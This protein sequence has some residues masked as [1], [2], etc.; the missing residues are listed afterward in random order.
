MFDTNIYNHILDGSIG[1]ENIRGKALFFATHIQIDELRNTSN[2]ARKEAL[3]TVFEQVAESE[4]PT[5][6]F[7][8]GVSRLHKAKLGGESVIPTETPIW[9]ISTFDGCKWNDDTNLYE[10]IKKTLDALN[11]N[12]KNNIQDALIAETA[13][14]NSITLITHDIDLFK[15]ATFFNCSCANLYQV[16]KEIK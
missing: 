10:L 7:V 1:I 12:K 6:S 11:K 3:L 13:I 14:K 9:D 2:F 5:E 16:L 8:T 15:V 4:I